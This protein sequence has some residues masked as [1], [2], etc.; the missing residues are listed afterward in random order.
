[1]Q[2]GEI[3]N[4]QAFSLPSGFRG[5][6]ALIVQLWWIV[7]ATLFRAS[8]QFMY[9]WR[10]FLLR[11][12][13]ARIGDS[14]KLRETVRITYPW[15]LTIGDHSWIGDYA[16]LYTLGPID[17]GRN[18]VISQYSYICTGSH[19]F[20]SPT[21]DI[22]QRR[23]VIEDE[24]WIAAG[25]FVHP[26]VTIGRGSVIAARSVVTRDTEPLTIYAGS[27]ATAKGPRLVA[28]RENRPTSRQ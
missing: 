8:P 18:A 22:Y 19:D 23:N 14:V 2:Q 3:Q 7:Q 9:G 15:K 10:V 4:L 25:A 17:I 13:G 5:R 26:G 16:E 6:S 12:F 24:A 11:V 21:F 27:P 1:M 20:R 28:S